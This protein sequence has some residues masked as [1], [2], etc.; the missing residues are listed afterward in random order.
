MSRTGVTILVVL[1]FA[2]SVVAAVLLWPDGEEGA[3]ARGSAARQVRERSA[4][5]PPEP[6]PVERP[7]AD[8]GADADLVEVELKDPPRAGLLFDVD[9]GEILWKRAA[10][11]ELAI[12]SL[13]KMMT[14]LVVSEDHTAGERVLISRRAA[15]TNGSKIGVL[16]VGEKV[17]LGPLFHAMVMI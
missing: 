7:V 6:R 3:D 12:A 10:G 11:R 4:P 5:A 15:D 14:A 17:P 16:P 13:T 1:A 9:T 8:I 2:P